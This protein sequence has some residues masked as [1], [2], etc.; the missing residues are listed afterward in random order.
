MKLSSK[1]V[2]TLTMNYGGSES[3]NGL[4]GRWITPQG[5]G[6]YHKG[7]QH[8][9]KCDSPGLSTNFKGRVSNQGLFAS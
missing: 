8:D 3:K 1:T 9:L 6:S 5:D 4:F 2:V 7:Q